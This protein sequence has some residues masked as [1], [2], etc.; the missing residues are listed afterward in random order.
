MQERVDD[1]LQTEIN[2]KQVG[3]LQ[4][5]LAATTDEEKSAFNGA[6]DYLA[7]LQGEVK[8]LKTECLDLS[9]QLLGLQTELEEVKKLKTSIEEKARRVQ[10]ESEQELQTAQ[11]ELENLKEQIA[12]ALRQARDESEQLRQQLALSVQ[13]CDVVRKDKEECIEKS[14]N[15]QTEIIS[16]LQEMLDELQSAQWEVPK[17]KEQMADASK[18]QSHRSCNL[19]SKLQSAQLE[20]AKFKEQIADASKLQEQLQNAHQELDEERNKGKSSGVV[21]R[22]HDKNRLREAWGLLKESGQK[23][24]VVDL[25]GCL[26]EKMVAKCQLRSVE[27]CCLLSQDPCLP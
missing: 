4:S 20:I 7:Q 10:D 2:P 25:L 23:G 16:C 22:A 26:S 13:A 11:L 24:H 6:L 3:I 18:L 17:L 1:A 14:K 8:T 15:L 21:W 27:L 9:L 5:A 19:Q 12:D